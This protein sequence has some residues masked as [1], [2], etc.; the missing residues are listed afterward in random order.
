MFLI[1]NNDNKKTTGLRK[2]CKNE[3]SPFGKGRKSGG[4]STNSH[5]YHLN[6]RY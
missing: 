4:L 1:I 2:V 6:V 3:K 5:N